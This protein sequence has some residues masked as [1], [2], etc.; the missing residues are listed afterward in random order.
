MFRASFQTSDA[1]SYAPAMKRSARAGVPT[2]LNKRITDAHG[3]IFVSALT[4]IGIVLFLVAAW[5]GDPYPRVPQWMIIALE[6]IAGIVIATGLLSLFWELLG[7]RSLAAEVMDTAVLAEEVRL[8][9]ITRVWSRYLSEEAWSAKFN[10]A[11][12]LDVF[13]AYA[14][15]WRE[16]NRQELEMFSSRR[17]TSVRIVLPDV[18]DPETVSFI[19]L[20]SAKTPDEVKRKINEA[21]AKYQSILKG[22]TNCQ[23]LTYR[24]PQNYAAYRFDN[25]IIF[26]L[27]RNHPAKSGYIP[28]LSVGS[29]TLGDFVGA[30]LDS[31][32]D[33]STQHWSS[34]SNSSHPDDPA[35]RGTK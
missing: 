25:E 19:A 23:I 3:V 18:T 9:G 34:P 13:V 33:N 31:V 4:V 32:I 21:M 5:L 14:N 7:K 2:S 17:G 15:T 16:N 28:A 35:P 24:G 6:Q 29:G 20:R 22:G 8:A 10:G 27:Y 26:T 11:R 12:Q 1:V 30:D